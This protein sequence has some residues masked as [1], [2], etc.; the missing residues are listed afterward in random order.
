MT[1]LM[2]A[3]TIALM[4]APN[5]GAA[6]DLSNKEL[7][8]TRPT[9]EVAAEDLVAY[10][11]HLAACDALIEEGTEA[12]AWIYERRGRIYA[13]QLLRSLAIEEYSRSLEVNP[14]YIPSLKA[15]ALAN[16][17][18]GSHS[19][20]MP[21]IERLLALEPDYYWHY[22]I[23]GAA[24][25]GLDQ[26]DDAIAALDRSI[27]LRDDYLSAWRKRASV[28]LEAGQPDMAIADL[29]MVRKMRPFRTATYVS[30][31]QIYQDLENR[32][33]ALRN[34][35]IAFALD[36]NL[37]RIE[38]RINEMRQAPSATEL[39]PMAYAPPANG[40]QI[41]YLQVIL[42]RETRD[43]MEVAI[44]DL[45]NW[46]AAVERA[47]PKAAAFI[48]RTLQPDGAFI[49][50]DLELEAQD[51]M[52]DFLPPGGEL[53]QGVRSLHGVLLT[54]MRPAGDKGPIIQIVHDGPQPSD[55]WPLEVGNAIS[56]TGRYIL[57]CP[58]SFQMASMMMGCRIGM[59]SLDLGVLDYSLT[60]DRV[61]QVEV[62]MGDYLTYVLRYRELATVTIGGVETARQIESN[63]WIDP[64]LNYWVKQTSQVEDDI[65]TLMA[66]RLR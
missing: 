27:E 5:L 20:A 47:V 13:G 6:Q 29:D 35:R 3:A 37:Q 62:P 65:S 11:K 32:Q 36:P 54:D 41:E 38:Y 50:V 17:N 16:V 61:E 57:V 14:D 2:Q 8:S 10:Q 42:P 15:R 64:T 7:C 60:V 33:D 45:F 66:V 44:S 1:R 59:D 53:P 39:P 56:G 40:L 12:P 49:D 43:E 48:V 51:R 25:A 30:L 23:N 4:M 58:E 46:F 26:L 24:L 34:Y 9:A 28:H 19:Q 31:G 21:D 18:S 52:E 22:Y 63:F 55:I